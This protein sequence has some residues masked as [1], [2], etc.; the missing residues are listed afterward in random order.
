MA[1][2]ARFDKIQQIL[3]HEN[4][5]NLE[6]ALVSNFP[7]V[8][9]KVDNFK[10]GDIV[11][12]IRDDSKLLGYDEE[13]EYQKTHTGNPGDF[14][15]DN[16]FSS[17]WFWQNSLL[18]YLGGGG[19]VKSIKLRGKISMG[20]LLKPK[21][22]RP[23]TLENLKYKDDE[24]T[25]AEM[26]MYNQKIAD[27]EIGAAYLEK[28][29]GIS[30][31]VAPSTGMGVLNVKFAGLPC[32]LQKTDQENHENLEEDDLHLGEKALITKK[33]DGTSTTVTCYPDKR[34][35]D[36]SSR[37][38]TFNVE[39][40]NKN[41][42]ENVYTKFTQDTVKAGIWYAKK[43]NKIIVLRGET[44]CNSVQA[45][46]Y[47]KDCQLNNFFVYQCVFPDEENY[48]LR[49]GIYG[50]KNHFTEI[51]KEMNDNGFN[52]KTVP[53]LG[54]ETITKELLQKYNDI[55]WSWGEGIVVNIKCKDINQPITSTVWSYKSKSRSYLM[56][57][58]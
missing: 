17:T 54:E 45:S 53:I 28:Y 43:Y 12:Y 55:D 49:H 22:V 52:I 57:M 31:W 42:E 21:D 44:C 19:R 15:T 8:V 18:K 2:D 35:Y 29:F 11:F 41:S 24:F 25:E 51:V 16:C 3:P 39:D 48:F 33:L 13:K 34:G 58:K 30:H 20:I 46:S 36:I 6:I 23:L 40:M 27:P 50:T 26:E 5:D 38:L 32:S 1:T 9:R 56:K 10:V 7:C 4:S 47:N 37:S 14:V